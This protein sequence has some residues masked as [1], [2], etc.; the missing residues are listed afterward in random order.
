MG[1]S[2]LFNTCGE[3]LP[4]QLFDVIDFRIWFKNAIFL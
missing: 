4:I 1:N 3:A 2:D